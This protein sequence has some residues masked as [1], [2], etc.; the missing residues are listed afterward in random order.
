M[1]RVH[2]MLGPHPDR[3]ADVFEAVGFI[4]I[5]RHALTA[6]LSVMRSEAAA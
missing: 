4:A 6:M 2:G 1:T 5:P 3:F